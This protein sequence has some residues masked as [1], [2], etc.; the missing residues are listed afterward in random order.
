[1]GRGRMSK[2]IRIQNRANEAGNAT[3]GNAFCGAPRRGHNSRRGQVNQKEWERDMI[4]KYLI[5]D[6]KHYRIA[7]RFNHWDI[8]FLGAVYYTNPHDTDGNRV[9][10]EDM[11]HKLAQRLVITLMVEEAQKNQ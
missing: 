1:M 5:H 8:E 6:N 11:A 3:R 7:Y 10:D 2:S 4:Q 9:V